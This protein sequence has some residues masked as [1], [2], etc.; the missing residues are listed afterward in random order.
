MHFVHSL[1]NYEIQDFKLKKNQD[2]FIAG[3]FA[4]RY[5]LCSN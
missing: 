3:I 4:L 2:R 1:N 5:T